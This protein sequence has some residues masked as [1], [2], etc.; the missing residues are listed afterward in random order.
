MMNVFNFLNIEREPFSTSPD[1]AFFCRT[2]EHQIALNRLEIFI[3]MRRGLGLILGDVGLGKTTLL[4]T[5]IKTFNGDEKYQFHMILDPSYHSEQQF[6]VY[7]A[8]LFGI[9]GQGR[10]TV[11]LR[12]AIEQYLLDQAVNRNKTVVLLIDE[13]QKLTADCLEILRTLLNYETNE[14]KLLQVV[15]FGQMELLPVIT[16]IR[17]FMDRVSLKHI[18]R[19]VSHDEMV[20]LIEHR[21]GCAGYI[22]QGTLF[23]AGA[24]KRIYEHTGGYPRKIGMLCHDAM[25]QL[26]MNSYAQVTEELI[27]RLI[28]RESEWR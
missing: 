22:P 18:I 14:Y 27:D 5:L 11:D 25:E 3:R 28:K 1:P 16:N 8:R 6:L 17:N 4:R 13:G 20:K 26:I 12:N 19:P 2:T 21:L 10:T 15:I 7:L 23:T 9:A 24:Y